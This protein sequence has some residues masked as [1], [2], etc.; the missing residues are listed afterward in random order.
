MR[1]VR[2]PQAGA[3]TLVLILLPAILLA[4]F[5]PSA[6]QF[7]KLMRLEARPANSVRI[8]KDV[9][10]IAQENLADLRI[11][12]GTEEIPYLVVEDAAQVKDTEIP[13]TIQDRAVTAAGVEAVLVFRQG[14]RHNRI[15]L[16][17]GLTNFK[18]K[19]RLLTTRNEEGEWATVKQ[20]G[21]IFDFTSEEHHASLLTIDYPA[22]TRRYLKVIVEGAR[23][24][25]ILA[26]ALAIS[27]EVR[28]AVW[29]PMA[30]FDGP[31]PV[32]VI[33]RRSARYTL[34]F[35]GPGLPR[36]RMVLKIADPAFHRT[37]LTELSNDGSNWTTQNYSTIYR[38]QAAD[39]GD[40]PVEELTV[41]VSNTHRSRY[42]RL[43][44][45]NGDNRALHIDQV[46]V[47][48]IAR[49]V[50]FP[51]QTAG[52]Y[53]MYFGNRMAHAPSYDLGLILAKGTLD[54]ATV[55]F[56]EGREENPGYRPLPPPE[57]P[58]SDRYPGLLYGVLGAAVIGLAL[59]T[60]RFMQKISN[61]GPPQAS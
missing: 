59:L 44:I 6:W 52:D 61:D 46:T 18:H 57:V 35:G 36:D 30:K 10:L 55:G 16:L 60:Y 7:R 22:S 40:P 25:A 21:Y 29:Q 8:D 24:P 31:T 56:A 5:K 47:E 42:A 1:P 43:T 28:P 13:V 15:K 14:A 27:R 45:F 34:D 53:W 37:V 33:E 49:H 58:F 3:G 2:S 48:A 54:D 38:I 32:E 9:Y 19:V 26:G 4:D 20:G 12:H 17:T 39:P 11:V 50:V 51:S 41:P 23:D